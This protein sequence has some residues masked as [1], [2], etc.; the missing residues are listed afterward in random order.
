MRRFLA[1]GD[2]SVWLSGGALAL[3][4]LM[5]AGLVVVVLANSL[6]FFWP[7]TLWEL[8]LASGEV[9]LA[10][11]TARQRLPDDRPAASS[12][13]ASRCRV[14]LKIANR[15]LYGLDFRWVDEE[16]IVRRTAPADAAVIER[17]EWGHLHGRLRAVYD[18]DELLGT[19]R[20]RLPPCGEPGPPR[21][22]STARSARSSPAR[23][24]ASTPSSRRS[25]WRP[26][27]SNGAVR[28]P[29]PAAAWRPASRNCG[30]STA[31]WRSK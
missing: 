27:H 17:R 1:G 10:C 11:Q 25:A 12:P 19:A 4:L 14:Q 26:A 9:L 2:P 15:D 20:G 22:A 31:S 23:C 18:G 13:A 28:L 29:R 5:V 7:R 8:E 16:Q 6:G 30:R 3:C 21:A 24:G